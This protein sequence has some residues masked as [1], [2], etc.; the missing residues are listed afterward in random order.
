MTHRGRSYTCP[1]CGTASHI[2]MLGCLELAR[3]QREQLRAMRARGH[4]PGPD[5]AARE[6]EIERQLAGEARS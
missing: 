3:I 1:E 5:W 2:H 4:E 6:A